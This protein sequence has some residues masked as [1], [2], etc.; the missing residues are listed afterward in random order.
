MS[1]N[2]LLQQRLHNA[3]ALLERMCNLIEGEGPMPTRASHLRECAR[4]ARN[5]L[6][7]T[8]NEQSPAPAPSPFG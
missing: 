5:A 8:P 1:E 3:E 6:D 7:R 2:D 4:L